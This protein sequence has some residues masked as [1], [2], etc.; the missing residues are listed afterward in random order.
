M[1]KTAN[2][3]PPKLEIDSEA[4]IRKG[5][6]LD[7]QIKALTQQ[8]NDEV[9]APL[10]E[11]Y[12]AQY[13]TYVA[14]DGAFTVAV[15]PYRR[16]N[17]ARVAEMFPDGEATEPKITPTAT[18]KAVGARWAG[19]PDKIEKKLASLYDESPSLTFALGK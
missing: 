10:K 1:P 15:K 3:T 5:A 14:D 2:T 6:L 4:L 8:L 18:A 19:K 13:D 7:I 17:E 16:L 9:K 12:G 11:F